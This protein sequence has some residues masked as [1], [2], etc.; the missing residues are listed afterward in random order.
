MTIDKTLSN[1]SSQPKMA[2]NQS[3]GQQI[4]DV[5]SRTIE[6][7][8]KHGLDPNTLQKIHDDKAEMDRIERETAERL[9]VTISA[10]HRTRIRRPCC[11][12]ESTR[13]SG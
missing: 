5:Q 9:K 10:S 1:Q 12:P 4:I 8:R 2:A 7:I 11:S 13:R 3:Q 6:E